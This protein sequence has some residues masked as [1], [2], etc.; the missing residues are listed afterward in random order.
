MVLSRRARVRRGRGS[1]VRERSSCLSSRIA[2]PMMTGEDASAPCHRR[3]PRGHGALAALDGPLHDV[4][5]LVPADAQD[6]GRASDVGLLE[7]TPSS[8]QNASLCQSKLRL[9]SATFLSAT[10]TENSSSKIL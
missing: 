9:S 8:R 7:H 1:L 2:A 10:I 5:G 3:T 4:P 6:P